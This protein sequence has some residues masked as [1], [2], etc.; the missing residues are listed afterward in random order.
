MGLAFSE[1]QRSQNL[2]V[3]LQQQQQQQ[4]LYRNKHPP[5]TQGVGAF[6]APPHKRNRRR[7][8]RRKRPE[9]ETSSEVSCSGKSTCSSLSST[10]S[11]ATSKKPHDA[12]MTKND[13]YFCLRCGKERVGTRETAVGRV[14]IVNWDNEVVMDSLVKVPEPVKDYCT[15][16]TGITP[17]LLQEGIT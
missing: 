3:R 10:S 16:A 8:R 13:I 4:Q 7:Q 12:P 1:A 2:G 17:E 6:D 15:A 11:K 9:G 5:P 14:T